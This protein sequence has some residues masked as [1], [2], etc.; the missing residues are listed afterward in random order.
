MAEE[1]AAAQDLVMQV[2]TAQDGT[3]YLLPQSLLEAARLTA[4]EQEA[5]Q[6]AAGGEDVQGFNF[7]YQ[8]SAFKAQMD[9]LNT[10]SQTD[11]VKLQSMTSKY[12]E[13]FQM[14]STITAQYSAL[15][16]Q[17]IANMR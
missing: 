8:M 3:S 2:L 16:S 15:R 13:A 12:T 4:E 6:A 17:I 14:M 5:V 11:M 7:S 9:A 1:T 10:Q